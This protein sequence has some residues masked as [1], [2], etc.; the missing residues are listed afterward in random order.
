MGPATQKL[1]SR[2]IADL[3]PAA[4]EQCDAA[5]QVSQFRS[6]AEVEL[7][8]RRTHL[9]IEMVNQRV[10]LLANVAVLRL[11]G[12][13]RGGLVNM[14]I[15]GRERFGRVDVRRSEDGLAAQRTDAGFVANGFHPLVQ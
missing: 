1:E 14:D 11:D 12:F 7:G 3:H 8:T 5:S 15:V 6:F 4:G 9:V 13:A 10:F 2:P